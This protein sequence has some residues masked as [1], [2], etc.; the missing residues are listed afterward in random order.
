M[1]YS[2]GV[3]WSLSGS[4]DPSWAVDGCHDD[5][6]CF[7]ATQQLV[8]I[9]RKQQKKEILGHSFCRKWSNLSTTKN[10]LK[11]HKFTSQYLSQ[12]FYYFKHI[13]IVEASRLRICKYLNFPIFFLV[14]F[15]CFFLWLSVKSEAWARLMGRLTTVWMI[16]TSCG[17][18]LHHLFP[19]ENKASFQLL[20]LFLPLFHSQTHSPVFGIFAMKLLTMV[21]VITIINNSDPNN[22][23]DDDD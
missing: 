3:W 2:C 18:N 1:F 9:L 11:L 12:L 13:V 7:F 10:N 22:N 6:S 19:M 21:M 16:D 14:T 5:T 23:D 8:N 20:C 15:F 4:A 17:R